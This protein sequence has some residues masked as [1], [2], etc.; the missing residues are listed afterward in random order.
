MDNGL[1]CRSNRSC[2]SSRSWQRWVSICVGMIGSII[3]LPGCLDSSETCVLTFTSPRISLH[4]YEKPEEFRRT[5]QLRGLNWT[6]P[7]EPDKG[8]SGLLFQGTGSL[9]WKSHE[10]EVRTDGITVDGVGVGSLSTGH[11][12]VTIM[13]D[14]RVEIDRFIPW[15]PWTPWR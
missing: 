10:V 14:G 8:C 7:Q 1:R 12:N 3:F 4:L 11:R 5:L 6:T 2:T 13:K 15:E 9:E